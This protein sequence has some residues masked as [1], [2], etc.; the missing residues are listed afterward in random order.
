MMKIG[1]LAQQTRCTTETIRYYEKIGLLPAAHRNSSNYRI[2]TSQH[3]EQLRFIRNCRSLDMTH[4][5]IRHL[6]SYMHAPNITCEPVTDIIDDHLHHVQTRIEEL[7]HL[8]QQLQLIHQACSHDDHVM[9][10]GI[11]EQISNMTPLPQNET[12]LG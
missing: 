11:L 5:E 7:Q 2:Y 3:V 9:A 10:C 1:E 6:L 8:Q 4:E 12:H